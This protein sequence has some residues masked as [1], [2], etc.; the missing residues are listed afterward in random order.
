M[1]V[2]GGKEAGRRGAEARRRASRGKTLLNMHSFG[3]MTPTRS[4][5]ELSQAVI[6]AAIEV[7][8]ELGP[9]LL[10]SIYEHCLA[11]ELHQ[12]GIPVLR[13]H[14]VNVKYKGAQLDLGFRIDLWVDQRIIVEIKAVETR[15]PVHM[16][17]L[18]SY[19]KLTNC[20]LGLL[21]NFNEETLVKG[22]RRVVNRFVGEVSR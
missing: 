19:L 1:V 17:Q 20:R 12:L 11:Q 3:R 7:H 6:G 9:G 4:Y 21:I 13:Q 14:K 16:A 5:D 2:L 8:R 22:V 10:E 18:L 15:H